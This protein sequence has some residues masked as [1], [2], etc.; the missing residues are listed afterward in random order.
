[1]DMNQLHNRLLIISFISEPLS[2]ITLRLFLST[3]LVKIVPLYIQKFQGSQ[4]FYLTVKNDL[5]VATETS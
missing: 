3:L 5:Q 2:N 1:M 4:M